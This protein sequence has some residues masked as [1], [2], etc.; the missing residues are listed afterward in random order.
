MHDLGMFY[1]DLRT[2]LL[3]WFAAGEVEPPGTFLSVFWNI[4]HIEPPNVF[5]HF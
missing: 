5:G 1:D 3:V 4:C 2:G